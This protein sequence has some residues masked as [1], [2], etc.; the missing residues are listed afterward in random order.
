MRWLA[1]MALLGLTACVPP[2]PDRAGKGFAPFP[3]PQNDAFAC[4]FWPAG[5]AGATIFG[6]D[7]SDPAQ[8]AFTYYGNETLRLQA[9]EP[10]QLADEAATLTYTI[11]DYSEF[12][13]TL[14]FR[15]TGPAQY[16]GTMMMSRNQL[17]QVTQIGDPVDIE[18]LCA[19]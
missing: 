12:R 16:A 11:Y 17:G 4:A 15:P 8:Q 7:I 6:T 19:G 18:G 2:N 5:Q 13:L 10:V 1:A 9:L 14:D 3:S